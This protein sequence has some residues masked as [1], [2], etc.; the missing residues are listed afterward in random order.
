MRRLAASRSRKTGV[1]DYLPW[2]ILADAGIVQTKRGA[3]LAGYEFFPPDSASST[4]EMTAYISEACHNAMLNFGT[5]WS[6][7]TDAISMPAAP[8]ASASVSAFPDPISRMIDEE[9][10]QR[11]NADGAHF[12]NARIWIVCYHP[13]H[14]SLNKMENMFYEDRGEQANE[15]GYLATTMAQFKTTLDRFESKVGGLLRLHRMQSFTTPSGQ[16]EDQLVNYLNFCATGKTNGIA[17]PRCAAYL[18]TLITSQEMDPGDIP[19][20]GGQSVMC[21]AIDGFPAESEANI[22]EALATLPIS[23]RFSQRMIYLDPYDAMMAIKKYTSAWTGR[24]IPLLH[25]ALRLKNPPIDQY[26]AA[27]AAETQSQI[28]RAT[29]GSV[30]YGYYSAT[31]VVRGA[32]EQA[33]LDTCKEIASVVE[34]C[35][36]GARIERNNTVEAW[37][38]ALPGEIF[39]QVRRPPMPSDCAADFLPLSGVW[40]G[41]PI[42]PNPMYPSAS[43][44]LLVAR[45]VGRIPFHANLHVDDVG[46]TLI[47]GPTGGGKSSLVNTIAAQALRYSGMRITVFDQKR[48]MFILGQSCGAKHYELGVS[49]GP[50]FCPLAHLE[51][52][53]DRAHAEDWIALCFEL[54]TKRAPS[55]NQR[56]EIHLAIE[57]LSDPEAV[58][59]RSITDFNLFVQDDEVTEAMRFYTGSHSA[60]WLL[61]GRANEIEDGNWVIFETMDLLQTGPATAL[62]A[63]YSLFRRFER[64]LDGQP[65]LLII[66]EAWAAFGH[67]VW[68]LRLK[69]WL[70]RLR[71]INCA[72][73]M[74]TQSLSDVVRSG[75]LDVLLESCPTRIYLPNPE[76]EKFGNKDYPGPGDYYAMLGLNEAQ[77]GIIRHAQ[78]K[79]DYYWTSPNGNRIIDLD[80]GPAQ[81]ALLASTSETD[82]ALAKR[83]IAQH[84]DAWVLP[85]L[86]LKGVNHADLL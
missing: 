30:R 2:A 46:H 72:V 21:V 71:S 22:I 44:A 25:K 43:P 45:T 24:V 31:I 66:A 9:R 1:S 86:E 73:I 82:V 74:D 27:M 19:I 28:S 23:Y 5:G 7:W 16:R 12:D 42:A 63:L 6:S 32:D 35:Q 36:F 20:I 38:G 76:A 11:F 70:K 56:G 14:K 80:L 79:R 34:T 53:A 67:E 54:Q 48:G 55:P 64:G 77:R 62:P 50:K 33:L 40:L 69:S 59:Q 85:Y 51:T 47:F 39:A 3:F 83:L 60:G 4:K 75:M 41:S 58:H 84:G 26:A 10:R 68:A 78:G 15:T 81:R 61:D 8:Y 65:A 17:L 37:L 57:R 29:A 49:G 18:D 13:P 52:E